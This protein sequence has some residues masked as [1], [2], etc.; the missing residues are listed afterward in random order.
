MFRKSAEQNLSPMPELLC[1]E[2]FWIMSGEFCV[3]KLT[4][5]TLNAGAEE[6]LL[7]L[8]R[9]AMNN[10]VWQTTTRKA[11][12]GAVKQFAIGHLSYI[13]HLFVC[14]RRNVYS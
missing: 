12:G 1:F 8:N 4:P 3:V 14:T 2:P 7:N 6:R 5:A 10:A 11:L 9:C 13:E